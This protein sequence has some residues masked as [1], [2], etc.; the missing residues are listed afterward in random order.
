MDTASAVFSESIISSWGCWHSPVCVAGFRV[1]GCEAAQTEVRRDSAELL[2]LDTYQKTDWLCSALHSSKRS[3]LPS[4]SQRQ[5]ADLLLLPLPLPFTRTV[6]ATEGRLGGCRL[7]DQ[8]KSPSSLSHS[9]FLPPLSLSPSGSMSLLKYGYRQPRL[10]RWAENTTSKCIDE[11]DSVCKYLC[12]LLCETAR[13]T[14]ALHISVH[15]VGESF[16]PTSC[17]PFSPPPTLRS[18]ASPT[19]ACW[20]ESSAISQSHS[21]TQPPIRITGVFMHSCFK[22][23][24][25]TWRIVWHTLLSAGMMTE[26]RYKFI[27][28]FL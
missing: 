18:F 22:K 7:S 14:T 28:W 26:N 9:L 21:G 20:N 6:A 5:T 11:V 24:E 15:A 19:P 4:E 16:T 17:S 2:T 25:M 1:L 23:M 8:H 27:Y 13:C 10:K 12:V 3:A